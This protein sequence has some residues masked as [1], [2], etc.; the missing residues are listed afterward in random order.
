MKRLLLIPTKAQSKTLENELLL[1]NKTKLKLL[2]N[3]L[4]ELSSLDLDLDTQLAFLSEI[5]IDPEL[6]KQESISNWSSVISERITSAL[7]ATN[8]PWCFHVFNYQES[9]VTLSGRA[10]LIQS[11]VLKIFKKKR[12]SLLRLLLK[13]RDQQ[14][15]QAIVQV[16]LLN[17]NEAFL[18]ISSPKTVKQ[19]SKLLSYFPGGQISIK[20]DKH[21]P[22]RAYK[23]LL[24]MELR[25]SRKILAGQSCVDLG[26]SPG[27]WSYI[28]LKRGAKVIS[29]DRSPLREDLMKN[30]NLTF[31]KGDAFTYKPVKHVDTLLCDLIA[32]PIRTLELLEFWLKHK[33]CTN[34]FVTIKFQG[35]QDLEILSQFK[36]VLTTHAPNAYLRQLDNN[37]NEVSVFGAR[38]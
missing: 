31:I 20:E 12:R 11:E 30:P 35:A 18:A 3:G 26:S 32:Y 8:Y 1:S 4:I 7:D 21:A 13:E 17:N 6:V 29:I 33:L 36:R 15:E 10:R 22:S 38:S 19:Y 28:A 37:K 14:N 5:L 16:C 9:G 25:C 34:F 2:A 24:E 27:G 23:K